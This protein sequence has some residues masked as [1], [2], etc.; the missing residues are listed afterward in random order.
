MNE[1]II[2]L[3]TKT[4]NEE[5]INVELPA[6][7]PD[8]HTCLSHLGG[9]NK[10][11]SD[12]NESRPLSFNFH[13][14][15]QIFSRPIQSNTEQSNSF[16]IEINSKEEVKFVGK[17][18]N[19]LN[20][21]NLCDFQ[22]DYQKND[23]TQE[24]IT[25]PFDESLPTMSPKITSLIMPPKIFSRA[26]QPIAEDISH[27]PVSK[28]EKNKKVLMNDGHLLTPTD[29]S[30]Y[31]NHNLLINGIVPQQPPKEAIKR[32]EQN[33]MLEERDRVLK[34]LDERPCWTRNKL[35][36]T[37][38]ISV[39]VSRAVLPAVCYSIN[40]GA[41]RRVLCRFGFNP[42]EHPNPEYQVLD[43][44]TSRGV[45]D[46]KKNIKLRLMQIIDIPFVQIPDLLQ[47]YTL[48]EEPTVKEGWLSKEDLED[49][50]E[51]V[52]NLYME[53]DEYETI[54]TKNDSRPFVVEDTAEVDD[55]ERIVFSQS[56]DD[57]ET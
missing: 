14:K 22:Y 15:A 52:Y 23:I 33:N 57:M 4:K 1:H 21:N 48:M 31:A 37:A 53:Q 11:N 41:F 45:V 18:K 35:I 39:K 49:L 56:Y 30:I 5:F 26:S 27:I 42:Y 54:E 16:L 55:F 19:K 9:I 24:L 6:I 44:R 29:H 10:V 3:S 43:I 7:I 8:E 2:T 34:I 13:S 17:I 47:K 38:G 32:V 25:N 12:L 51:V 28:Q 36:E 46:N 40:K 50:R 20:F